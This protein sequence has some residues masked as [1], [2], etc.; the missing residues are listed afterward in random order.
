MSNSRMSIESVPVSSFMSTNIK[1]EMADQTIHAACRI[2]HKNNIGSV[3]VVKE[4]A[5]EPVGIITERDI[6]R[7]IGSSD[8]SLLHL[9]LRELMS[10]PLISISPNSSIKDALQA[11]QINKIRRLPVVKE[12]NI[13][14]G[15][16]TDKDVFRAIMENQ[17]LVASLSNEEFFRGNKPLLTKLGE[18]M[19]SKIFPPR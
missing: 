9:P 17:D 10:K 8:I 4:Y 3:I 14:V 19:F 7:I 6:V 13:I 2:M 16:I 18:G 12:R 5:T 1:S 11:M 15:I